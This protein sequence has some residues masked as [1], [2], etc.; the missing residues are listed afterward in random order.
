M[1]N[2]NCTICRF[3]PEQIDWSLSNVAISQIVDCSETTVRRHK[4]HAEDGELAVAKAN[5]DVPGN[6]I[7]RRKWMTP[8]GEVLYS[9]QN[10]VSEDAEELHLDNERIDSLIRDWRKGPP[11][12][13]YPCAPEFAFPADLQLGKAGEAGGGTPE[14]IERFQT[15]IEAVAERW[16]LAGA[17]EGYLCDMGD[18]IEN[19]FN[20]KKQI[21]TNDRTLPEQLEDAVAIYVNAIGRLRSLVGTLHVATV[22][23]NH[24]EARNGQ[25]RDNNPYGSENDWGLYIFRVIE[26]AV[27]DRGWD[28]V[29]FH[30]PPLNEDTCVIETTDG[31][32]VAISHGHFTGNPK[33]VKAW[34][35]RQDVGRRPGWDAD[36]WVFG[37]Y[38][39][40]YH[41]PYGNGRT[42][43]GTPSLD[44]GSAWYTK[45]SGEESPPGITC[46]TIANGKWLNHSVV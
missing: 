20:T 34:V 26:R 31:T 10:V 12:S 19:I 23:S 9:Y 6:W 36:I 40:D 24:G 41:M 16:R 46:L 29:V 11:E 4:K 25:G 42:I 5:E 35:E 7:P 45:K 17:S 39:H 21:S 30:R 14:T 32:K 22:T 44:P 33:G 38:H 28:N 1:E 37:H 18:L 13:G 8:S 2:D 27:Q 43:F 3:G 15:S